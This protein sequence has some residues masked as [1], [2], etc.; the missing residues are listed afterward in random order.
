MPVSVSY[1]GVYIEEVPSG[2]RTVAGIP[3]S[4]TAFVGRALKG[5]TNEPK[6][7]GSFADFERMFGELWIESPLGFAVQQ[8]FMNGGSDAIIVRVVANDAAKAKV[9]LGG[10]SAGELV[11]EASSHGDWA[12]GLRA[13]VDFKTS[14]ESSSEANGR[15]FNVSIRLGDDGPIEIFRNVST[16]V[17]D[18][19]YVVSVLRDE[20]KLVRVAGTVPDG[21]GEST[22]PP[23]GT[24][25]FD[26]DGRYCSVVQAADRGANGGSITDANVLGQDANK[27]GIYAL[28]KTDIFNLVCLPPRHFGEDGD[29][30]SDTW[31]KAAAFCKENRAM[32]IVDPPRSWIDRD[33]AVS[34]FDAFPL[35][36][37]NAALYFPRVRMANPLRENRLEDF[38]PCGVVAGVMARTDTARGVWK[39]PAGLEASLLGVRELS[40]TLVDKENGDL[41]PLGVN[42]LRTFPVV[43]SV[44]WGARTLRGADRLSSDWKYLSVRRVALFIEESLFRGTQWVVFEPNDEPLWSQIRL[45]VGSF[46]NRLFRQGAFQG[47]TPA[48][49]YLVKCDSTTTT[50]DDINRGVV[51]I[52]VGFAPLKPAEFVII[53]IQQLAGQIPT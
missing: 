28:R 2:V 33:T 18:K 17:N 20:S 36:D 45:N 11:L 22:D 9:R 42:C 13:R 37:E 44:V 48:E 14:D 4:V 38:A 5:P 35:R 50:Q 8:F 3:T 43:G 46:M 41:N 15:L 31:A 10:F 25:P 23:A 49:A 39:A 24:D 21:V 27:T 29:I 53:K 19:R 12:N 26:A 1:P 47:K 51:N 6:K 52:L 16:D 30:D 7:I 34:G 32:L 40:Y